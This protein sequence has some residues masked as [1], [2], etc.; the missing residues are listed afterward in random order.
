MGQSRYFVRWLD[1]DF[2]P[3]RPQ[4]PSATMGDASIDPAKHPDGSRDEEAGG[5][6]PV[7]PGM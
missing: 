6:P 5:P 3:G 7:D 1:D 4:Q 2:T